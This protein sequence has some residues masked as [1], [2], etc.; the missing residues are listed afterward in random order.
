M[1][2]QVELKARRMVEQVVLK[3]RQRSKLSLDDSS[4]RALKVSHPPV[5]RL[6][7]CVC[8]HST[9]P[10]NSMCDSHARM[11]PLW[12]LR[13]TLAQSVD[14]LYLRGMQAFEDKAI[15]RVFLATYMQTYVMTRRAPCAIFEISSANLSLCRP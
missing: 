2:P 11:P 6:F 9:A 7:A 10:P 1:L 4:A 13:V 12:L 3:H 5:L 15:F 8:V 14:K